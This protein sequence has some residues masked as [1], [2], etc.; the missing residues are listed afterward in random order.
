MIA[1]VKDMRFQLLM[2][3]VLHWLGIKKIDN[4]ISMSYAPSYP[5]L[6][7]YPAPLRLTPR[8]PAAVPTLTAT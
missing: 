7:D 8:L 6:V 4:M 3:D 2:P 1:G 5:F